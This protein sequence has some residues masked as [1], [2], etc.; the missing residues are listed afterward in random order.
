MVQFPE[1]PSVHY[2]FMYEY[3]GIAI[4]SSLI[5]ISTGHSSFTAHRGF[6]QLI[7]SFFGA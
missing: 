4:V 2:V 5:R 1:F 7:A 3:Y 6:S